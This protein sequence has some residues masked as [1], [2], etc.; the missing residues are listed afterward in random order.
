MLNL[1]NT[2]AKK[3]EKFVPRNPKLVTLYCCG[4]TVYDYATIGNF[5]T[6]LM[7]DILVR[8]LRRF[9]Y[10]VKFVMNITDVGHLVSDADTGED[11]MEKGA[12]REGKTAW[13]IA[14]FYTEAFLSD[15]KKLNLLDPDVRP[16]PTEHIA[17]QIDMVKMLLDK[18]FAYQIDDGIYYDTSKFPTYGAL[19]GQ[20]LDELKAGAR[21]EHN[22]QK[23]NPTDFALWKCS[24]KDK[25]RDMEWK[26][27]WGM[28]FP[29]WHIECSAMSKKHLGEQID[30]HTG[31]AD[32]IPVHHTNEIAQ[33]EAASGK[34]PF[35]LFWVHG[36]FLLVDGA[37]MAKSK[38]NFYRL[39]DIEAKK[40]DPLALRY[41]YLSAHYQTFLN[42]TAASNS[43]KELTSQMRN[44]RTGGRN[45]LS[46]EKLEKVDAYRKQFDAAIADNLNT[47]KA[48]AVVWEVVKSNIPAPDK[49]DLII[50]FDE[51]LG[52]KLN[53][54]Q[55]EKSFDLPPEIQTLK[56][57]RDE[58]R[59]Q[60]KFAE[61][62]EIRKIIESKGYNVIDTAVTA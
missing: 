18:G 41:F 33:S 43:L 62:D 53:E 40:Y 28:G 54:I 5:R 61:A 1:Y 22:P 49:Y 15:S 35:V 34:S 14:K 21:V 38:G 7:T 42:L 56:K 30:I 58:F 25:K 11:K 9:G 50:D 8:T 2:A 29:G 13:D 17:E 27:P 57:Q 23:R 47:P 37:K 10:T 20:N 24:P 36:Q 6:Y 59:S 32:L 19:T 46:A 51:V 4:P 31:G 60:K 52:L 26:S 48:L 39:S 55:E 16:K 44:F 12:H 45:L 3:I